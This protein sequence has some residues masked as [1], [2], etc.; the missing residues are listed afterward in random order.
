MARGR[1]RSYDTTREQIVARAAALFAERGYSGTSMNDVAQACG[2]SKPALY[3]Y[4]ADKQQLLLEITEGHIDRLGALVAEVGG[5]H[6]DAA[7]RLRALIEAFVEV[8][9]G[10]QSEHRVLTEDVRFL[11]EA[12]RTRVLDGQRRVV[13]AFADAL[14]ELRPELRQARLD[15]PVTMLLFGMMN[16]MFTWLGP[17]GPLGTQEMAGIVADLFFGGFPA[18]RAPQVS[19]H[20]SSPE[21]TGSPGAPGSLSPTH[22][23]TETTHA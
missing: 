3:H 5:R 13:A 16:W 4:V 22:P 12:D 18:V 9:H 2:I 20:R 8:Y 15:K 1:A 11:P 6:A 7:E 17:A 14:A 23:R 21:A 10:A 19:R